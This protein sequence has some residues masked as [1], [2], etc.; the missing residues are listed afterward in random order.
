VSPPIQVELLLELA[1]LL[2][3]IPSEKFQYKNW[4]D[5]IDAPLGVVEVDLNA[6]CGTVACAL[7]WAT[8]IPAAQLR[9]IRVY[10]PYFMR[11]PGWAVVHRTCEPT[12]SLSCTD[13]S[14]T[15][16][17]IAFGLAEHEA[18]ALFLPDRPAWVSR[19]WRVG[20]GVPRGRWHEPQEDPGWPSC[21]GRAPAPE[22]TAPQVANWIRKCV[23]AWK[24]EEGV[25]A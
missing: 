4:L 17:M 14:I 3:R 25:S 20:G 7:G 9:F 19:A 11:E 15:A 13:T 23:E 6:T 16:A 8:Q 1:T 24:P 10:H 22:A 12:T 5:G 18:R 2:D 21:L